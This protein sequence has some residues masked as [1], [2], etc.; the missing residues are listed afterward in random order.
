[1]HEGLKVRIQSIRHEKQIHVKI[2]FQT[3][4]TLSLSNELLFITAAYGKILGRK[5]YK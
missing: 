1:M 2:T 5:P 3:I 4:L